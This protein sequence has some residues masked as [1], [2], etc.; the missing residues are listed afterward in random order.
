M[1]MSG[2]VGAALTVVLVLAAVTAPSA[3]RGL[4]DAIFPPWLLI[5]L[6]IFALVIGSVRCIVLGPA[7]KQV[8]PVSP[9]VATYV[10]AALPLGIAMLALGAVVTVALIFQWHAGSDLVQSFLLLLFSS[11]TF[12]IAV[13]IVVNAQMLARHWFRS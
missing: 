4:V 12:S 5:G 8:V 3:L 11:V 7:R 9:L 10:L 6:V 1:S 13:K 2:A